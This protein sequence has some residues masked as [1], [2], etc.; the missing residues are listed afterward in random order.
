MEQSANILWQS[1]L[2]VILVGFN[3]FFAASEIAVITLN[4][5][6]LE[7]MAD[8]GNKKAQVLMKLIEEPS[9]FL[10]TIQVGIT[11]AGFLASASA[12]KSFSHIISSWLIKTGLP[13]LNAIAG[14]LSLILVVSLLTFITLVFGELVPKS[15]ALQKPERISLIAANPLSFISRV[16]SPFVSLLTLSTNSI[17]KLFGVNPGE[18]EERIT[19]EEIKLMV[20]VGEEKGAIREI[21]KEMIKNIFEFDDT[22]VS[23]IMTSR[24]DIVALPVEAC[25]EEV[26][27][28]VDKEKFSRIPVYKGTI[29]NIIG[30]LHSKDL[31]SVLK[32]SEKNK[33]ELKKIIRPPYFIH[34][35]KKTDELFKELKQGKN[36]IAIVIDDFG[37]TDG[38]VTMED[39]LEEIVG[40]IFDEDDI[41][42]KDIEKI[43]EN[44]YYICGTI[45]LDDV[46]DYFNI[47]MPVDEYETLSGFIIGQIGH[48]PDSDEKNTVEFNG[49]IFKVE[50]VENKTISKVKACRV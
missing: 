18:N 40:N 20:D 46:E 45:R 37:G 31:I 41:I 34:G 50:K 27:S 21:E 35:S 12:T 4:N 49:M 3:A 36:H 6:K 44:T 38:L 1:F 29:D 19:E 47:K 11:L 13:F 15:L 5:N 39:L 14:A 43:D 48:I 42:V 26:I 33:F 24:M 22:A 16:T 25:L 9:R 17:M 10:S 23:K 30:I 28:V 2:I 32:D 8:E 7:K